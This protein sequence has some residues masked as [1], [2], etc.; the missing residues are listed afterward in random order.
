M[1]EKFR[2]TETALNGEQTYEVLA[3]KLKR[4]RFH[5]QSEAVNAAFVES[6]L[7]LFKRVLSIPTVAE[8]VR[9]ADGNF[10]H[11]GPFAK[12]SVL[13]GIMKKAQTCEL[14]EWTVLCIND[15]FRTES[16]SA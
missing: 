8:I 6:A 2:E 12:V 11:D 14:I 13:S 7:T 10:G 1:V 4:A 15:M 16:R 5:P 3:N 9:K